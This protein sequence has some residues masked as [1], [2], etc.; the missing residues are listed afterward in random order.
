[1]IDTIEQTEDLKR[2]PLRKAVLQDVT[3][4]DRLPPHSLEAEKAVLGCVMLAPN[5]CMGECLTKLKNGSEVFYD[6]RNQ[7][8]FNEMAEMYDKREPIDLVTLRQRLKDKKLLEE[9]GGIAYINSFRELVPI[10]PSVLQAC[11][12]AR[13]WSRPA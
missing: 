8:I 13:R 12:L 1:M 7:V 6:L 9:V 3:K 5:E 10:H 2:T 4:V 11:R